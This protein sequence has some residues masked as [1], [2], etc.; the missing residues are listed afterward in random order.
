MCRPGAG[1]TGAG[2]AGVRPLVTNELEESTVP[3]AEPFPPE[4][5]APGEPNVPVEDEAVS[6]ADSE[7]KPE[8]SDTWTP[9]DDDEE[10]VAIR[11][12]VG[13]SRTYG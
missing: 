8:V 13:Y 3:L 10:L 4:L 9:P 5:V 11:R 6:V 7:V 1:R 12:T 2:A